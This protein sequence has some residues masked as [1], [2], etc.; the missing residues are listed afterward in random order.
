MPDM[1]KELIA[2]CQMTTGELARRYAELFGEATR[3]WNRA[4]LVRKIAWKLQ[5]LAEGDL[6]DRARRRAEFDAAQSTAAVSFHPTAIKTLARKQV[7]G[8]A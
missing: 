7:G 1:E 8:A 5:A 4:Y 6:S 3:S 2:L